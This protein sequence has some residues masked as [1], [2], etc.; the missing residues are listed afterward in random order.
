[1]AKPRIKSKAQTCDLSI[2]CRCGMA[3]SRSGTRPLQEPLRSQ[4]R[5]ASL[6]LVSLPVISSKTVHQISQTSKLKE[7][8]AK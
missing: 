2:P 6:I 5:A 7:R 1:M 8:L 4:M 3:I